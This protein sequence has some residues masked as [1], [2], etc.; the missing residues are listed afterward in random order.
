M[1]FNNPAFVDDNNTSSNTRPNVHHNDKLETTNSIDV[2]LQHETT[3]N[4]LN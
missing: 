4:Y 3:V 1:G 2:A